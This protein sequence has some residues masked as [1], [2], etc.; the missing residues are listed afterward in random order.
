MNK[1]T[2]ATITVHIER[3]ILDGLPIAAYQRG[4]L[5]T[6]FEAELARLLANG[7]LAFD[8]QTGGLL[9]QVPAGVLELKADESIDTLGKKLARAIY[10]GI[11]Q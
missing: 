1:T 11:G 5:Q 8:L 10:R 2:N 3:V 4:K 7:Q 6:A 9:K